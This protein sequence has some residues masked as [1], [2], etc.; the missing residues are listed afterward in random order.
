MIT[1]RE[2]FAGK[3]T[4]GESKLPN[5]KTMT[6]DN[7]IR[8]ARETGDWNGQTAEFNDIGLERF[9]NLVAAHEREE[10]NK[11]SQAEITHLKEQLMRANTN[12]GAYK[13]AF[14]AGQMSSKPISRAEMKD[15]VNEIWQKCQE[16]EPVTR[17]WVGL[18]DEEIKCL[19]SWW[20]SYEDAPALIQLV[21]DVEAKLK[22]KNT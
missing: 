20:P 13:A 18:T 11:Q 9:A 7:I 16:Q 15:K 21:K 10:A 12:D 8:M 14:L 19:P 1:E 3:T 17:P 6:R 2:E 5:G 22:E 4:N